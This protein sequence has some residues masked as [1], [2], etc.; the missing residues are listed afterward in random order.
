MAHGAWRIEQ[1][2]L[3]LV[4]VMRSAGDGRGAERIGRGAMI[5]AIL[6]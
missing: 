6:G 3:K 1:G 2:D 5:Q 4:W